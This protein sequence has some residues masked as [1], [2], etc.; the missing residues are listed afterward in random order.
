MAGQPGWFRRMKG[1]RE[2]A[3]PGQADVGQVAALRV[4]DMLQLGST[5]QYGSSS[6]CGKGEAARTWLHLPLTGTGGGGELGAGTQ[7]GCGSGGGSGGGRWG[8]SGHEGN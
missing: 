2:V 6:G 3:A 8:D 1:A 7:D 5:A 4:G